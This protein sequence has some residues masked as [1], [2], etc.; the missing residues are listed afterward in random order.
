MREPPQLTF[1]LYGKLLLGRPD[2]VLGDTVV[3]SGIPGDGISDE[4]GQ[5][6]LVLPLRRACCNSTLLTGLKHSISKLP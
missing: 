6:R 5:H 3:S 4:K 2:R 1:S